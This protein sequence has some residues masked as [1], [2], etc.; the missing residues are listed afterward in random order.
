MSCASMLICVMRMRTQMLRHLPGFSLLRFLLQP[1]QNN[2][3][4]RKHYLLLT[5]P[6]KRGRKPKAINAEPAQQAESLAIIQPSQIIGVQVCV[7]VCVSVCVCVCV[8]VCA[9]TL[10][11]VSLLY[12]C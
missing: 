10:I 4:A 11:Q 5:A 2:P 9:I 8:C 6:K 12:S 7:C 3:R 1:L